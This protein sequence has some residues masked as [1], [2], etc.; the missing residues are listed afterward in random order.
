MLLTLELH[1]LTTLR[2]LTELAGSFLLARGVLSLLAG[3]GRDGNVVYQI[4]RVITRP[5]IGATRLM[6][7]KR[8]LDKHI[9]F[10]AFFLFLWLWIVL[11]YVRQL[12]FKLNG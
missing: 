9:P 2:V 6:M 4:L 7:P 1:V 12:I 8:I 3:A 11:A 10:V 5:A